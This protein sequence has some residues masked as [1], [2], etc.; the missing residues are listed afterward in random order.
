[1][2]FRWRVFLGAVAAM[3]STIAPGQS[4]PGQGP[5]SG[6]P[7]VNYSDGGAS[8]RGTG[9]MESI[10]ISPKT[11][12]PFSLNLGAEWSRPMATGG[13]F[14]LANERAI[15]RDSRGR[16]YQERWNLVPKGGDVKSVMTV[17]QITDPWQH[18]WYNCSVYRKVCELLPYNDSAD[19]R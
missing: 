13:T 10:Y 15:V 6:P 19:A 7:V 16:I 18:T 12:A 8:P 5:S 17:F 9:P 1:M 14:T 11:N 3:V 4:A 2:H